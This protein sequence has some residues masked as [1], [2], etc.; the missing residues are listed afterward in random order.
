M[1][2][3]TAK[4]LREVEAAHA[5]V[6][7]EAGS[8]PPSRTTSFSTGTARQPLIND[9]DPFGVSWTRYWPFPNFVKEGD[10]DDG[11]QHHQRLM[12]FGFTDSDGSDSD[13]SPAQMVPVHPLASDW[14]SNTTKMDLSKVSSGA[15]VAG[16]RGTSSLRTR[17]IPLGRSSSSINV[18]SS[19]FKAPHTVSKEEITALIS[20]FDPDNA[21][22]AHVDLKHMELQWMVRKPGKVKA[23]VLQPAVH[24]HL[25]NV[26]S[27]LAS[28][29]VK[30]RQILINSPRSAIVLM[31][32]GVRMEDLKR[33]QLSLNADIVEKKPFVTLEQLSWEQ[34]RYLALEAARQA[35]LRQV[36][37]EYEEV[38]STIT[39]DEI[40]GFCRAYRP[41]R[42]STATQHPLRHDDS[43]PERHG[44]RSPQDQCT[45]KLSILME[46]FNRREDRINKSK[47]LL[48]EK[49]EQDRS[50]FV[51]SVV[52]AEQRAEAAVLSRQNHAQTRGIVSRG[53]SEL[54]R[55]QR[56]RHDRVEN[57]NRMVTRENLLRKLDEVAC[58]QKGRKQAVTTFKDNVWRMKS[59]ESVKRLSEER[60]FLDRAKKQFLE[61]QK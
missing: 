21:L 28:N 26:A 12:R 43:S 56:A 17:G 8:K 33:P 18:R 54:W 27:S 57:F 10:E 5:Q 24:L 36:T 20:I 31:R 48:H 42:P 58:V 7:V 3:L 11:V 60:G 37:Q 49:Q 34:R 29:T 16:V 1:S 52:R 55:A 41:D 51:E 39:L 35:K 4:R 25:G 13:D 46:A 47:R 32:N 59:E 53:R 30:E 19:T 23:G 14:V 44:T 38:C 50:S 61:S 22:G 6:P 2:S 45:K 9:E 15:A 40:I